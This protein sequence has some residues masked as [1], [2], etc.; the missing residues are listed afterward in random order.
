MGMFLVKIGRERSYEKSAWFQLQR[1]R[2]VLME[3]NG[4]LFDC[5]SARIKN[6]D[7]A[8]LRDCK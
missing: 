2:P 6:V 1:R 4:G 7:L 3:K 8:C 5:S